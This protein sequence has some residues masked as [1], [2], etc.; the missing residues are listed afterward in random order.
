MITNVHVLPR[1][2][3]NHSAFLLRHLW[4][5]LCVIWHMTNNHCFN[6]NKLRRH[7]DLAYGNGKISNWRSQ[8][9]S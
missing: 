6:G 3:I 1:F 2:F 9:A 7:N 8:V 4:Q 5:K